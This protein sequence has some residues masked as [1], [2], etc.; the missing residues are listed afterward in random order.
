MCMPVCV[1]VEVGSERGFDATCQVFP[2]GQQL[3]SSNRYSQDTFLPVVSALLL[4]LF[5]SLFFF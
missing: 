5:F 3:S 1:C 4:S 2:C